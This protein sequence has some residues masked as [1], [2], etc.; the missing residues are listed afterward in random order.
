MQSIVDGKGKL[1]VRSAKWDSDWVSH[2]THLFTF[3]IPHFKVVHVL[4]ERKFVDF[5]IHEEK[6]EISQSFHGMLGSLD[7][8]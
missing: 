2:L 5:I 8:F 3:D 7:V 6:F 4:T 1:R